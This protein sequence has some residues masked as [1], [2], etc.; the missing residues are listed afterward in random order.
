MII[1]FVYKKYELFFHDMN[2]LMGGVK[3][4]IK[5]SELKFLW[6]NDLIHKVDTQLL[7][8]YRCSRHEYYL[9]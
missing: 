5:L 7:K 9:I 4:I 8:Q 3:K 6:Q 1:P 2:L